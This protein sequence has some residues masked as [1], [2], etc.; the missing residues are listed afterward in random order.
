[1]KTRRIIYSYVSDLVRGKIEEGASGY[2]WRSFWSNTIQLID[3]SITDRVWA[4]FDRN[5]KI[6]NLI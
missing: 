2:I 1:M 6:K 5:F 3:H 4:N